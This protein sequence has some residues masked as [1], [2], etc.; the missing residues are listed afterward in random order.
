MRTTERRASFFPR[1]ETFPPEKMNHFRF[2]DLGVAISREPNL[3]PMLYYNCEAAGQFSGAG[4]HLLKLRCRRRSL[5][6]AYFRAYFASQDQ[7]S[8]PHP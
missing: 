1:I 2:R 6:R 8:S 4:L 3:Y 5:F 7:E